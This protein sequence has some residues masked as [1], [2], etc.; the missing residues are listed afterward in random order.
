M[1][2]NL[3]LLQQVHLQESLDQRKNLGDHEMLHNL[4]HK[5]LLQVPFQVQVE[6]LRDHRALSVISE[7]LECPWLNNLQHNQI[8]W[9]QLGQL[10]LNKHLKNWRSL[11]SWQHKGRKCR[12]SKM[13]KQRIQHKRLLLNQWLLQNNYKLNRVN[14]SQ[15]VL[16]RSNK[17][18]SQWLLQNNYK[19]S[20][21]NWSLQVQFK[22]NRWINHWLCRNSC[23]N[24]R[25]KWRKC[26]LWS[27]MPWLKKLKMLKRNSARVRSREWV[28]LIR[29]SPYKIC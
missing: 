29:R 6:D 11:S 8:N 16:F 12:Q 18:I 26:Q 13:R 27:Q 17:W 2:K 15:Q 20:K 28:L 9:N 4:H 25:P 5:H 21:V 22:S 7:V 10:T 24:N 1:V 3:Q 19:L 23:C 14:W